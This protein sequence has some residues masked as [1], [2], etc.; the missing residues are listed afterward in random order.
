VS[1]SGVGDYSLLELNKILANKKV[2]ISTSINARTES[3]SGSANS[4]DVESMFRVLYLQLTAPKV[5]A[6]IAEN[7]KSVLKESA[8]EALNNPKV[9]FQR[10]GQKYFYKN[11]PRI[12]FETNETIEKLDENEMLKIYKDRFADLNNFKVVIIGD[13][14]L[15]EVERLSQKYLANLP[16]LKREETFLKR[17]LPYRHGEVSFIRNYNNENI[18]HISLSYKSKIPYTEENGL[19]SSA[20]QK[21]LNI[22]LRKLIREEKSGVYGISAGVS[23]DYFEL[24]STGT[25]SFSCDPK[26]KD[27]LLAMVYQEIE[28]I[29]T[30]PISQEEMALF[31]KSFST[32]EETAFKEN[33]YWMS[34]MKKHYKL[35]TPFNLIYKR[36]KM[37]KEIT[38]QDILEMAQK[39]FVNEKFLVELNPKAVKDKK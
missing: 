14:T 7:I 23:L 29:K 37:V 15:E 39:I 5:D 35:G 19:V 33:W 8:I 2:S 6:R 25:I 26:R 38:A 13:I 36:A 11:N 30:Q 4:K 24:K 1:N 12:Q 10:E 18:S 9:R 21:I 31:R 16:T 3:I 32:F 27:E 28:K 34:N 17:E 20:L 22:R